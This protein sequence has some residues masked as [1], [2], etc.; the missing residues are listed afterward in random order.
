MVTIKDIEAKTMSPEKR[1]EA[2]KDLFAFYIGRPLSYL[3]TIPFI[4]TSITP[5]QVSYL[6]LLPLGLG[7]G[8]M[9]L[10]PTLAGQVL[11]WLCFFLWNLLD[12][13]DGNL[14]RY[15]GISS[16]MGSVV[17]A[18]SGYAAMFISYLAMGVAASYRSAFGFW[19]PEWLLVLGLCQVPSSSSRAWSCIRPLTRCRPKKANNSKAA[20]TLA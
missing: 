20:R 3:L 12:G 19:K 14:A 1:Q 5:N 18:M 2:K 11:A 16:P 6:S 10:V 8:L 7:L 13:V 15:K 4:N 9:L 17:D